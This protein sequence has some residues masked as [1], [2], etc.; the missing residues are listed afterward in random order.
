M[1]EKKAVSWNAMLCGYAQNGFAE[2]AVELFNEM[3][4]ALVQTD[5]NFWVVVISLLRKY[6]PVLN[7]SMQENHDVNTPP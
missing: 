2:E 3:T 7:R 4:N 6:S 5:K 1:P